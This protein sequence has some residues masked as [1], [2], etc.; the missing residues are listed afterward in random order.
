MHCRASVQ[1]AGSG[2]L[3]HYFFPLPGCA[4]VL[5]WM[6]NCLWL[7]GFT[8][9]E[10]NEAHL[11]DTKKKTIMHL[12]RAFA[13]SSWSDDKRPKVTESVWTV[14]LCD[15][16]KKGCV[17]VTRFDKFVNKLF[18]TVVD[19]RKQKSYHFVQVL[20]LE[21]SVLQMW[22]RRHKRFY[23][24]RKIFQ[25]RVVQVRLNCWRCIIGRSCVGVITTI[26]A[27]NVWP[28]GNFEFFFF[29]LTWL[30]PSKPLTLDVTEILLDP[31]FQKGLLT[32]KSRPI[33]KWREYY[34]WSG[35]KFFDLQTMFCSVHILCRIHPKKLRILQN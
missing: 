30:L 32:R 11:V 27:S 10:V 12:H 17:F 14:V 4:F 7:P 5:V 16:S 1:F 31:F 23:R 24:S 8:H 9:V 6:W 25:R 28:N 19:I 3:V 15:H 26:N 22:C 21:L 18:L 13:K 34:I 20:I 33:E 2:H 29:Q 35:R